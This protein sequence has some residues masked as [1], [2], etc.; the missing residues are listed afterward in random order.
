MRGLRDRDLVDHLKGDIANNRLCL[1]D[2]VIALAKQVN[3]RFRRLARYHD[4]PLKSR[5]C[6]RPGFHADLLAKR[7]LDFVPRARYLSTHIVNQSLEFNR[8]GYKT[9]PVN[10]R[11]AAEVDFAISREQVDSY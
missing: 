8:A 2:E 11:R 4:L 7:T 1:G 5:Y 6:R 9:R 10:T 3:A